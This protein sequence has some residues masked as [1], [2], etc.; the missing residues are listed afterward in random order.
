MTAT[1]DAAPD[2]TESD[3]AAPAMPAPGRASRWIPSRARGGGWPKPRRPPGTRPRRPPGTRPR[4]P[5]G[6]RP[7]RPPGTLPRWAEDPA[8]VGPARQV[9]S[10]M[11]TI[12]AVALIGFA[13]WL[14]FGSRLY[15]ARVQYES[16]ESFRV[17]LALG[18][19]PTGPT[20]PFNPSQLVAV[21]TPV[22]VLQIPALHMQDMVLE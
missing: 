3:P 21:G 5:P 19:A 12:L 2:V 7:R 1:P 13:V 15:Y 22:A 10:T 17:P 14:S 18:D 6:T 11:L 8:P 16:Y 4:R 20:N 9:A